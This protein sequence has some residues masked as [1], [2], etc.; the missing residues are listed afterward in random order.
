MESKTLSFVAKG[1][2]PEGPIVILRGHR[3][4]VGREKGTRKLVA[5]LLHLSASY[6]VEVEGLE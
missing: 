4:K 3:S 1:V 2:E 6:P 5:V